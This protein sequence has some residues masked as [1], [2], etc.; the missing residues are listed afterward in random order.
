MY[1]YDYGSKWSAKESAHFCPLSIHR[2][3]RFSGPYPFFPDMSVV[4]MLMVN[5]DDNGGAEN[6]DDNDDD[7]D[8]DD[9]N[10]DAAHDHNHDDNLICI[11]CV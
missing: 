11:G 3:R 9:D 10:D 5:R 4:M 1:D 7:D 8:H 6:D 2:L